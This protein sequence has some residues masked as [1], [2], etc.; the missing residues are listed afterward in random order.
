[1]SLINDALKRATQAQSA[2]ANP[3]PPER[4]MEPAPPHRAVGI[5][6][7]FTPVFLFVICGAFWF[8]YQGLDSARQPSSVAKVL[9]PN[10]VVVNARESVASEETLE[11]PPTTGTELP[12]PANRQFAL[13]DAPTPYP[14]LL[15]DRETPQIASTPAAAADHG[16]RVSARELPAADRSQFRLQGIFY[17]PNSPS[18]V[19]NSRTVFVGDTIEEAKVQAITQRTV[20]LDLGAETKVLTLH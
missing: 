6:S 9:S 1:M 10:P 14:K 3:A 17:R 7:Y 18:A 20:V 12:I 16:L 8:M 5:P 2:P 15:R 4:A 13:N 19:I 11:I